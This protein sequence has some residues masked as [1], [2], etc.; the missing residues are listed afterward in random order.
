MVAFA[1]FVSLIAASTA[2]MG[3]MKYLG[4]AIAGIDFGCQING[5]CPTE[6]V[7]VPL[8][9]LGG[10]DSADQMRHFVEDDGMNVFRLA[11]TWQYITAGQPS[12]KLDKVNWGNF[13]KLVQACLGTGA[14]CMLDLHN[15]ARYNG[16]IGQGGPTNEVFAALW[17]RIATH[18]VKEKKIIFGLM[19]EPHD[20]DVQ[21]WANSCQAAVTA[22]RKA[23]A[24]SQV[25]LLPGTNF[26]NAETF[27]SSGSAEAL[28]RITNPDGSTDNLMMDI[29]KYL[30]IDNSGSHK[31]CTTNNVA[32]F[33]TISDWLRKNKR[34]GLISETGASMHS[35]CMTR[36]CE[37]NEFIAKNEDVL[38]GFVA[39]GAGGFDDT[40]ILTVMPSKSGNTWT[41]NKLMQ[42]CILAP[43][44]KGGA[45]TTTS[46]ITSITTTTRTASPTTTSH[47]TTESSVSTTAAP[48]GSNS[49]ED[50][51]ANHVTISRFCILISCIT[52][53]H[54]ILD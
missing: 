16:I 1:A 47:S 30:D 39:W 4:V 48:T 37:Q 22:I 50:D 40:Y 34:L 7:Q 44:G 9:A 31:E 45:S 33:R 13:D 19:N 14:Y 46:T 17:T 27:V 35:S 2:V 6:N 54:F 5:D 24:T 21:L 18:Y 51:G 32:A 29:H 49:A 38:V 52:A 53:L 12:D 3:K 11:M 41:D 8:A 42:Q 28:A 10:A 43:F 26:T 36:F 15:F 20:L 25:I 23:G